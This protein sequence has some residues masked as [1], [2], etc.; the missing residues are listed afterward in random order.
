MENGSPHFYDS[1]EGVLERYANMVYRLAYARTKNSAD[2]DDILQEVFLRYLRSQVV[3]HDEEHCKAWLIRTTINCSKNLLS[4]AWFRRTTAMDEQLTEQVEEKSDV[5]YAV[6]SLPEKYR[7][8]VHLFYYED[9]PIA[10][11]GKL[12]DKKEAT[13]KTWL[14]RARNMLKGKLEEAIE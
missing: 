11:I 13:V 8:V 6:M 4:S 1:A 9:L 12:L 3:F 5:F 2:S 14:H 7:T 10:Q